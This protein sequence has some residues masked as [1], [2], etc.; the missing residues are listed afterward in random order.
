M[1]QHKKPNNRWVKTQPTSTNKNTT[2]QQLVKFNLRLYYLI[3]IFKPIN[4]DPMNSLFQSPRFRAFLIHLIASSVLALGALVLVF[5]IW[6]PSVLAQVVGVT[7]VFILMLVIDVI[8]G[9][10][11]TLII[12]KVGKKGLKF[13]LFMIAIMQIAVFSYGLHTVA[14]GRPA[15]LVFSVDQFY[16][17]RAVDI[18]SDGIKNAPSEYRHTPWFGPKW[19][20][21]KL[22]D[23]KEKRHQIIAETLAT[24]HGLFAS[25]QLYEPLANAKE[26]IQPKLRQLSELNKF[27]DAKTVQTTLAKWPSA[28]NWL[29]LWSDHQSMSV[30]LD[31]NAQIVS[32]VDLNPSL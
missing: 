12:Y 15:W 19:V 13:D 16:L 25:P 2:P 17:V 23:T 20:A 28:S 31:N 5:R 1:P 27:N 11:L 8:V 18:N 22:P 32:I 21:V 29:P 14:V 26:K 10:L 6:Y 30:L 9:P 3:S 24:G 4:L 7:H